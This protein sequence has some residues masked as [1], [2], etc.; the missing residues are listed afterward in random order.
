LVLIVDFA[1]EREP[2]LAPVATLCGDALERWLRC[3]FD[4][5]DRFA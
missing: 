2:P 3:A 4:E 5:S 1:A